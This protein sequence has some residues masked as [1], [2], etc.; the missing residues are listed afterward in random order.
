MY[1]KL[2]HS[3]FFSLLGRLT[4]TVCKLPLSN[5]KISKP[6]YLAVNLISF[7]PIASPQERNIKL[8]F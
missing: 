6:I 4:M 3:I 5:G 1:F 7:L 2:C 8:T